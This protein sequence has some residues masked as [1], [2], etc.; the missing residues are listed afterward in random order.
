MS[1]LNGDRWSA[2]APHLDQALELEGE[3]GGRF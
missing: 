1:V 3:E 2:I